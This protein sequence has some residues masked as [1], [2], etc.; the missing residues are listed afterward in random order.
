[1][2]TDKDVHRHSCQCRPDQC[3]ENGRCVELTS[4]D[5]WDADDD[6]DDDDD[7]MFAAALGNGTVPLDLLG[8]SNPRTAEEASMLWAFP[9]ALACAAVAAFM[10]VKELRRPIAAPHP[11]TESLLSQA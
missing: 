8:Y 9:A 11:A 7:F 1:M 5:G 10:V 6:E 4:L 3:S 2:G